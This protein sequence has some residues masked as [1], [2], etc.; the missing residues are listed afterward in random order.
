MRVTGR[1]KTVTRREPEV[2]LMHDLNGDGIV[3]AE[4]RWLSVWLNR[5]LAAFAIIVLTLVTV[6]GYY[7]DK[8]NKEKERELRLERQMKSST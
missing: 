1:R 6:V 3:T 2:T 4:E 7:G 5:I 8:L